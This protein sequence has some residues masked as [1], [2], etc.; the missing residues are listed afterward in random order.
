M[1]TW[2]LVSGIL[3]IVLCLYVAWQ[4]L[5]AGVGDALLNFVSQNDSSVSGA[6]G[7]LVAVLMLAGGIVSIATR[8]GSNGGD[9]ALIVLFA[10]AAAIGYTSHGIYKDLIV[11]STWCLICAAMAVVSLV[12]RRM[13]G[14]T[15]PAAGQAPPP[16]QRPFPYTSRDMVRA[17]IM[18][19][20][21]VRF[22]FDMG[23]GEDA[24]LQLFGS[25]EAA[26]APDTEVVTAFLARRDNAL[27]ACVISATRLLIA[28]GQEVEVHPIQDITGVSY[29]DGLLRFEETGGALS[30]NVAPE[31][32][33]VLGDVC[34]ASLDACRREQKTA[35]SA[36]G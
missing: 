30:L 24:C 32:G 15:A 9:I 4:S 12:G 11:W 25:V 31:T 17:H 21:A 23:Q 5:L 14:K 16:V 26:V 19:R 7:S 18:S 36:E 29:R 34:S 28:A 8:K 6:A 33:A 1:K 2:K 3:S 35:Q 13:A 27:C 10:L 20:Y 22:G